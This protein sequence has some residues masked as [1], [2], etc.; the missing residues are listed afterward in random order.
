M[1]TYRFNSYVAFLV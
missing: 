1:M